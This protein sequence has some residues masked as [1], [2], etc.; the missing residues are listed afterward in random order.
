MRIRCYTLFDI[1]KTGVLNRKAPINGSPEKVLEWEHNRNTQCNFDTI[2]QIISLRS[3]PENISTPTRITE[4]FKEFGFM[5][6]DE[7]LNSYWTF[8]F[9]VMQ[10]SVFDDGINPLGYLI[11]DCD[12]VPMIK[13]G[14]EWSKL[15]EFLDTTPELRNIYFEVIS[16]ET[17]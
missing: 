5:F 4:K 8:D 1:T 10:L 9:D 16:N 15:P 11:E 12:N 7:E 13:V 6:E 2:I 17:E 14:T 3:Q